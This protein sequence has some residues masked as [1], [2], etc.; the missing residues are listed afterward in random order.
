MPFDGID[1]PDGGLIRRSPTLVD[2]A[3]VGLLASQLLRNAYFRAR[4]HGLG[5][6]SWAAPADAVRAEARVDRTW[7]VTRADLQEVARDT[8]WVGGHITHGVCHAVF[9][10]LMAE[11]ATT[12]WR[13][14]AGNT[15]TGTL[16]TG[17]E[18]T[19]PLNAPGV[20]DVVPGASLQGDGR[21]LWEV[22]LAVELVDTAPGDWV[23]LHLLGGADVLTDTGVAGSDEVPVRLQLESAS[24][25]FLS[26]G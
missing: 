25:W 1:Y 21:E 23:T 2:H 18:V 14:A 5:A 10:G 7:G 6:G 4:H 12:A 17:D 13:L 26:V 3:F 8:K 11:G 16:D 24:F 15:E 9:S 20:V 22:I 19:V